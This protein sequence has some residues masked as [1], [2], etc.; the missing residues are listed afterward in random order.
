MKLDIFIEVVC[1]VSSQSNT[2][3]GPEKQ[4]LC[5]VF[6]LS[7]VVLTQW[8]TLPYRLDLRAYNKLIVMIQN[9][10]LQHSNTKF[11]M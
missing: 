4:V 8:R 11:C 6:S 5:S 3:Y 1:F 7:G 9:C 10:R 2:G